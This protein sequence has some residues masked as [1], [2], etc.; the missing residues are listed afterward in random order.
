MSIGR[1]KGLAFKNMQTAAFGVCNSALTGL[2]A[3]SG[4][5]VAGSGLSAAVQKCLHETQSSNS[6]IETEISTSASCKLKV[7]GFKS[8]RKVTLQTFDFTG[9]GAVQPMVK[10]T[11]D[12]AFKGLN[13]VEFATEALASTVIATLYENFEY[14]IHT[15]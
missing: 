3:Q 10:A 13:R 6:T 11:M 12:P 4:K 14:T 5:H 1:Y 8:T 7:T 9:A 15:P 2:H